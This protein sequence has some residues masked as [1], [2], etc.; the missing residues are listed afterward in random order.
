MSLLNRIFGNQESNEEVRLK[1]KKTDNNS[2]SDDGELKAAIATAIYLFRQ[3]V[4]DDEN[5]ILT[6]KRI[7]KPYKPWNSKIY[8]LRIH[9]KIHRSF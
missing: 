2:Q 5:Y 6:I 7:E 3:E 4:H 9:P 1:E 8:G